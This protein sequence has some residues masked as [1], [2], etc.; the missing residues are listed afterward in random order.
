MKSLTLRKKEIRETCGE[1]AEQSKE[2]GENQ[3]EQAAGAGLEHVEKESND[4]GEKSKCLH[5][6]NFNRECPKQ[7]MKSVR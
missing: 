7:T 3:T 6:K 5:G 1:G 4:G 2:T